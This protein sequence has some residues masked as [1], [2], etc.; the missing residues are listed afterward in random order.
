MELLE[1]RSLTGQYVVI[2][3]ANSGIGG[4]SNHQTLPL[5]VVDPLVHVK[6]LKQLGLWLV[7]EHMLSLLAVI[8]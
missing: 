7:M 3:G 5:V 6:A 4:Y 1:G 8:W 2:T